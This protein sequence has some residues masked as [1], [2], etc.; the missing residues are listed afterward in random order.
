MSQGLVFGWIN[1]VLAIVSGLLM[2]PVAVAVRVLLRSGAP[3]LSRLAMLIGI[4]ANVAIV[5]LQ[6]LL[7]LGSLAF[8][9][10]IGLVLVAFLFLAVWFLM[11]GYLGSR[12]WIPAAR[13]RMGFLAVTYVGYPIWAFRLRRHLLCQARESVSVSTRGRRALKMD[14]AKS[15]FGGRST[16]RG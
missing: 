7:V 2:L 3:Q 4:G 10:E 14:P 16:G 15:M 11:T 6:T 12:S 1:D 8:A 5:I 9:G 13:V